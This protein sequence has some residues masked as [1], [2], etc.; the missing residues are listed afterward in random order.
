MCIRDSF[1]GV[2]QRYSQKSLQPVSSYKIPLM[3]SAPNGIFSIAEEVNYVI[4][5][6]EDSPGELIVHAVQ[7]ESDK[8]KVDLKQRLNQEFGIKMTA[9]E[10]AKFKSFF[11]GSHYYL[12]AHSKSLGK[13]LFL[14]LK[15]MNNGFTLLGKFTL[16][17]LDYD[18]GSILHLQFTIA[19][20]QNYILI[21]SGDHCS[22][23][24]ADCV[25]QKVELKSGKFNHNKEMT[26]EFNVIHEE[27]GGRKSIRILS[28]VS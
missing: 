20:G 2:N 9:E 26:Q 5:I 8:V 10:D 6:I 22:M 17:T 4:Q 19:N 18:V 27:A 11:T 3:E 16:D 23:V 1:N 24:G 21:F 12:V 15:Y 13:A 25:S 7:N 28:L 14:A